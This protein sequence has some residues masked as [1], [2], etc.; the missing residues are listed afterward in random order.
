[1]AKFWFGQVVI[2][3]IIHAYANKTKY[4]AMSCKSAIACVFVVI[5]DSNLDMS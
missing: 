2:K 1:M 3:P 5:V 4:H